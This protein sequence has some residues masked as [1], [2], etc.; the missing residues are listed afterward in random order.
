MC[1]KTKQNNNSRV[2]HSVIRIQLSK[3]R[4]Q[5]QQLT[6]PTDLTVGCKQ[7]E[8]EDEGNDNM[9]MASSQKIAK[10]ICKI[11]CCGKDK[12]RQKLAGERFSC[13][14]FV[15]LMQLLSTFSQSSCY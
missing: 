1:K 13:I 3:N 15:Q 7:T 11:N 6:I 2:R 5:V 9:K 4:N 10:K 12:R 14:T 8:G